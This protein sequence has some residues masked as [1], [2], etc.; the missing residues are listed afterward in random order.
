MQDLSEDHYQREVAEIMKK[1]FWTQEQSL[2][3]VANLILN[4][5]V[6]TC[7]DKAPMYADL[8][9]RIHCEEQKRY[10]RRVRR[11]FHTTLLKIAQG[12][13]KS[14]VDIALDGHT[15]LQIQMMENFIK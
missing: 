2:H 5:A 10:N 1:S 14:M 13:F 7:P 11:Y 9:Y 15:S 12:F 4:A 8:C 3:E 6:T